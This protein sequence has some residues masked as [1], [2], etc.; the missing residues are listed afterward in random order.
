MARFV[1]TAGNDTITPATISAG[2][3]ITPAGANLAGKDDI[4]GLS[5]NDTIQGDGSGDRIWGGDDNDSLLGGAG[6]DSIWG[7]PD[8]DT[9]VGGLDKDTLNADGGGKDVLVFNLGDSNAGA[10]RD[11]INHFYHPRSGTVDN[12]DS[13]DLSSLPGTLTFIGQ[14]TFNAST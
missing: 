14:A 1:G 2:V 6:N 10:N 4:T 13:I 5:G 7:G 9:L 3:V 8:N 12:Y 11:V